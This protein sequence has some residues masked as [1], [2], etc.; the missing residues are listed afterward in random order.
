MRSINTLPAGIRLDAW[1][2]QPAPPPPQDPPIVVGLKEELRKSMPELA[3][4][5]E[6]LA[7][8]RQIRDLAGR[9]AGPQPAKI[10]THQT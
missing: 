9:V 7:V 5:L 1:P 6:T 3:V 4:Q 8:L 10:I 2:I